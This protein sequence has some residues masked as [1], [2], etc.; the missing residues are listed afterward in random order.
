VGLAG[1]TSVTLWRIGFHA[2]PLDPAPPPHYEWKNRWDDI[3]HKF[4]TVYAADERQTAFA[5]VVQDFRPNTKARAEFEDLFPG[6]TLPP[7]SVPK[8][9]R[10]AQR[11]AEANV[12]IGSGQGLIDLSDPTTRARVETR[13]AK[14]LA[15]HHWPHLDLNAVSTKDR[16]VTQTLS[17]GFYDEEHSG[18]SFTSNVWKGQCHALYEKRARLAF[19]GT[20]DEIE[21]DDPDLVAVCK[22]L[23]LEIET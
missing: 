9:W 18:V 12:V 7:A 5:E 3:Q 1:A 23:G 4:R 10:E 17:R 8:D 19:A 21:P 6:E 11:I 20:A 16:V 15:D 2:N 22:D 13:Y 14:L